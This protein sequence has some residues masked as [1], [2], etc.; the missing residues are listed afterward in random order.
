MKGSAV[1][2]GSFDP[3]TVGHLD[4]IRRTADIFENVTVAVMNN[5]EKKPS[6]TASE[7]IQLLR[8]IIAHEGLSNVAVDSFDGLLA[9]YCEVKNIHIIV[10]GLR[11]V[12][13]FEYEFQMSLTNKK[14]CN[15][16]ETMFITTAAENLYLSSSIVKQIARFGGDI[17][18]FIPI[19]IL[20]EVKY[21]L[22]RGG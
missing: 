15:N 7:R 22:C 14:L 16:L 5:P 19:C 17:S 18:D 13:D 8:R 20:E 2:P 4:I 21:R 6:F 12:S 9:E 11:A 10:K 1:C 3:V